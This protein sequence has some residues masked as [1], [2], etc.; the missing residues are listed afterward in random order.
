LKN[1]WDLN[2]DIAQAFEDKRLFGQFIENIK[3]WDNWIA[4]LKSFWGLP[5]NEGEE[6]SYRIYTGRNIPPDKPSKEGWLICS[7]RS[8]KNWIASLIA[9]Y[10]ALF[11]K[12]DRTPGQKLYVQIVSTT[13]DQAGIVKDYV[14][15]I[16]NE[17]E[18]F[19]KYIEK[20]TVENIY[21]T[22]GVVISVLPS[23]FR[24]LRG[25][26]SICTIID[27][28]AWMRYEGERSDTEVLTAVRPSLVYKGTRAPLLCLSSPYDDSGALYETFKTYY[29]KENDNV[30][31]WRAASLN[32]NPTLSESLV[33]E[34]IE[35][36]PEG[37]KSE[38]CGEFRSGLSQFLSKREIETCIV[39]D[40]KE[41][42][43][44]RN[45]IYRAFTDPSGGASDSYTL[46]IGHVEGGK[47]V[48]DIIR[49]IRAPFNPRT[50]T[51]ELAEI[52]HLYGI[53]KIIGD[54][55]SKEWVAQAWRDEGIEYITC[56]KRKSDLYLTLESVIR[57]GAIEL[58][59]DSTLIKQ[60]SYLQRKT[61]TT[62]DS[63]D[64]PP[65]T[66][67][68]VAN[69]VAGIGWAFTIDR[70]QSR[71]VIHYIKGSGGQIKGVSY[72]I[73]GQQFSTLYLDK[74]NK[75][76]QFEWYMSDLRN[77][78]EDIRYFRNLKE[79]EEWFQ[80]DFYGAPIDFK[81]PQIRLADILIS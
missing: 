16:L 50:A 67:D 45:F 55:Y 9:V 58:L 20:E 71:Q 3:T 39:S 76:P 5:L 52:C 69:V 48:L 62:G 4:F 66:H 77:P 72:T 34:E 8:G 74:L 73:P 54:F 61:G 28:I 24:T 79:F 29:G 25:R 21:L 11:V 30:L 81:R 35:R 1:L 53:K 15:A 6:S 40:R 12:Y 56:S 80:K 42:P 10:V 2:I 59:D 23:S 17:N 18:E 14:S 27:E 44:R 60:L 36:D 70:P 47:I 78:I 13:K 51:H 63:I 43:P 65:R 46:C 32:M 33:E 26:R 19:S 37:A 41:L 68:D 64:H 7:R 57:Q 31:V 49:E 22:N 38:W 75:D